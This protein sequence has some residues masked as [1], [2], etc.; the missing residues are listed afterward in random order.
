MEVY[1]R[2]KTVPG[3]QFNYSSVV[4]CLGTLAHPL[5][6]EAPQQHAIINN[7]LLFLKLY[8]NNNR[9]KL[10]TK[11]GEEMDAFT[12]QRH[13]V[14]KRLLV[15]ALHSL[16]LRGNSTTARAELWARLK[17]YLEANGLTVASIKNP[18]IV[19][20]VRQYS[21]TLTEAYQQAGRLD[22]LDESQSL[23]CSWLIEKFRLSNKVVVNDYLTQH[24]I[25]IVP[26]ETATGALKSLIEKGI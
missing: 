16:G 3:K 23:I 20:H 10:K 14:T 22:R 5:S 21:T 4:G 15:D 8:Y 18:G 19:S 1:I 12:V 7:T 17:N 25:V 26:E 11:G 24:R 2:P 13:K 6:P 9:D